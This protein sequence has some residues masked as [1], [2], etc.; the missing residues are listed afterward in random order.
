VNGVKT[1]FCCIRG[2]S[3]A[4]G[5]IRKSIIIAGVDF[6]PVFEWSKIL[7]S[8]VLGKQQVNYSIS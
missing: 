6:Y 8:S 1:V 7:T 4:V 5:P 2:V 3:D